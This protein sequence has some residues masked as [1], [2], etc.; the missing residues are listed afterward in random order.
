MG[1][2][3]P[4]EQISLTLSWALCSVLCMGL[5]TQA[6]SDLERSLF[7]NTKWNDKDKE[8]GLQIQVLTETR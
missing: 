3:K 2:G 5:R 7:L 1:S 4:Q 8:Q 6:E